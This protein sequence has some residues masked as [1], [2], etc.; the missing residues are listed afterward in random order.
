MDERQISVRDGMFETDV[1]EGGSGDPLLYLHGIGGLQW[2]DYLDRLSASHRVVAPRHPGFGGSTGNDELADIQDLVY[3]YLDLLDAL[4]LRE[5][6]VVGHSLGAMIAAELAAVQPERFTKV[7][8]ISPFG[9]WNGEHPGLDIFGSTPG[10]FASSLFHDAESE[11][12][13]AVAGRPPRAGSDEADGGAYDEAFIEFMLERAKAMSTSAKYLWPIPNK[14]LNK[15]IH[16]VCQPVLLIWGESDGITPPEL[17][18]DYTNLLAGARVEH[19]A[20]AAHMAPAE[21]PERV[22]ELV[23]GFLG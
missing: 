14:G 10:E 21:Q 15:R 17:A 3:Y 9:L 6:P 8:L 16:R 22:A 20:E 4:E 1:L 7:V 13:K 18:A 11:A 19:V 5:L 2:D 12:A 23:S